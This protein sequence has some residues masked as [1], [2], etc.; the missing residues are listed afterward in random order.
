MTDE[1]L[2]ELAREAIRLLKSFN[3]VLYEW[4]PGTAYGFS[5]LTTEEHPDLVEARDHVGEALSLL[6]FHRDKKAR[7]DYPDSYPDTA[8]LFRKMRRCSQDDR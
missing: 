6:Q 3:N 4:K 2:Q 1:V 7:P 5:E 8:K